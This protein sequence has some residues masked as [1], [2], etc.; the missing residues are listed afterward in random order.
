MPSSKL[1][2]SPAST[3]SATGF[4]RRS[5]MVRGWLIS[6]CSK[7]STASNAPN[8]CCSAP[9]QQERHTNITVHGEKRS[10][11]LAQIVRFDKGMFVGEKRRD[12]ENANPRGPGKRETRGEP[13]EQSD[14]ANVHDA[15]D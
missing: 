2:R 4:N 14:D 13:R 5:V 15:R 8:R 11:E 12:D 10:V 3:L 6:V 1:R 9:E 7:V